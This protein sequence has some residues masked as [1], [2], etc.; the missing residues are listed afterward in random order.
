MEDDTSIVD[1][2]VERSTSF[3]IDVGLAPIYRRLVGDLECDD[4]NTVTFERLG[5]RNIANGS[6]N[7][8]AA[9]SEAPGQFSANAAFGTTCDEDGLLRHSVETE[10]VDS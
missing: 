3:T 9:F 10:G 4:L 6:V 8:V 2:D 7:V 1:K 5:F